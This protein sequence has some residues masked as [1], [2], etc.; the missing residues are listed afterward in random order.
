MRNPKMDLQDS[1]LQE[2]TII[3]TR[4]PRLHLFQQAQHS[5]TETLTDNQSIV[6][7]FLLL[8]NEE[9]N[10]ICNFSTVLL[11]CSMSKVQAEN[12]AV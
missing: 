7:E 12:N 11:K 9:F 3:I 6:C 5:N 1:Y 10:E 2:F 8:H 4:L